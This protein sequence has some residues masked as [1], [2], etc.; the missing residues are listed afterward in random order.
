[1]SANGATAVSPEVVADTHAWEKEFAPRIT[2]RHL[3]PAVVLYVSWMI[4]LAWV[5]VDRWTGA[6]Q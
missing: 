6:L 5:A 2:L 3:V 4:F 1:M